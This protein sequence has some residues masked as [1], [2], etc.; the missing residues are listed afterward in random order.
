MMSEWDNLWKSAQATYWIDRTSESS[1]Q[2]WLK[3][4]KTEGDRL[5]KHNEFL[6]NEFDDYSE[7][8]MDKIQ[9]LE[10]IRELLRNAP[11]APEFI[12]N[13][14]LEVLGDE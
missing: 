13:L 10:E 7:S 5:Q 6:L 11:V 2:I 12:P 4:V 1:T 8:L 3:T 9:K 14:I